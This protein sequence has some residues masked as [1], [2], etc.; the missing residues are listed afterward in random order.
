MEKTRSTTEDQDLN[1]NSQLVEEEDHH[2]QQSAPRRLMPP[3][4]HQQ[5]PT[6]PPKKCPRCDS[7]NTK[8]CYYNNYSLAQPRYFCKSCRRYWTHGGALRNVPVG[9]GCRKSKR[10]KPSSYAATSSGTEAPRTGSSSIST[11]HNHTGMISGQPMIRPFPPPIPPVGSFYSGGPFMSSLAAMQ[12]FMQQPPMIG[13]CS[14][15]AAV[16]LGS[17]SRFGGGGGFGN[18]APLPGIYLPSLKSQAP[19]QQ[20]NEQN[21][22]YRSQQSMVNN[23]SNPVLNSWTQ[24]VVN[25]RAANLSSASST[26]FWGGGGAGDH[27]AA[28]PSMNINPNP[29]SENDLPGYDPSQ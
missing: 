16:N 11:H 17:S 23:P 21:E 24:T 3:L 9:G 26:S 27:A 12:S 14:Q 20:F 19:P 13:T 25:S 22:F 18:H 5:H 8:F 6:P 10:P 1:N 15:G 29:W 4:N 7:A 28:G 2:E